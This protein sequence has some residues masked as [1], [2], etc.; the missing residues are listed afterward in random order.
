M[1]R[2]P[3]KFNLYVNYIYLLKNLLSIKLE[4]TEEAMEQAEEAKEKCITSLHIPQLVGC[5]WHTGGV[6]CQFP[7]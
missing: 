1:E 7:E 6:M 4:I 5:P 3:R 2:C